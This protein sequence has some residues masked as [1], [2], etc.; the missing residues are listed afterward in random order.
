M[1]LFSRRLS[2]RQSSTVSLD[3]AKTFQRLDPSSSEAADRV[4]RARMM[5]ASCAVC[6]R[7]CGAARLEGE[8]G[9]CRADAEVR[10]ASWH[11]HHGEEPYISG[12]RGSGTI[13]LSGCS[14]RC[15][16]CQNHDI[17]QSG[18]GQ[19]MDTASLSSLMLELQGAGAHNIN[20]VSP[21]HHGPQLLD[22]ILTARRD[23]LTVPIVWNTSGY[24]RVELL[25]LLDGVVDIYLAD[26]RYGADRNGWPLSKVRDYWTVNRK[27]IKEMY[28]QVGTLALDETGIAERG[29]VVRHLVLPNGLS[30]SQ[31]I[32]EFLAREI[33]TDTVVNLMSQY[34]PAYH[35]T[36]DPML[37]RRL[38][39][40][41]FEAA[42]DAARAA[43]LTQYQ[44]QEMI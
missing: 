39:R 29:L 22:A 20:F 26:M 4:E 37:N 3:T 5:M 9:T 44:V 27:A 41:E 28:R 10:V 33:S 1:R 6:P 13:F 17:S 19:V 40:D 43:G 38:T 35:A 42:I 25:R 24:E 31:T 12:T 11:L 16:Y 14:L 8:I 7:E 36:D 23:G 2:K 21:T 18:D 32:F 34:Y 15:Q 30:G